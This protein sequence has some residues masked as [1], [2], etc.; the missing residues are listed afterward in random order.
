MT[1]RLKLLVFAALSIL[2]LSSLRFANA[3]MLAQDVAA[4]G[5]KAW[6]ILQRVVHPRYQIKVPHRGFAAQ[7]RFSLVPQAYACGGVPE[8]CDGT[9]SKATCNPNCVGCGHCPDCVN[10]PCTLYT[11]EPGPSNKLCNDFFDNRQCPTC[12]DA[13][14]VKCS[15]AP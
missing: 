5:T 13:G 8:P 3:F 6:D 11:C 14:N 1:R 12:D 2:A 9:V 10:G 15:N 4:P 7:V